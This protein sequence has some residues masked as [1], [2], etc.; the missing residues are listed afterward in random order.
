MAIFMILILLI[1]EHGIFF[2]CFLSSLIFLSSGFIPEG[3]DL[4]PAGTV[5]CNVF[6][7]PCWGVSPSQEAQDQGPA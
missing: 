3:I 7:D 2:I 1:H 4:I 6:G 5:L